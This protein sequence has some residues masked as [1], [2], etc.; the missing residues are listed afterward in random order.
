VAISAEARRLRSEGRDIVALSAGEPD[1]D[2][3]RH[4]RE[5]AKAAIDRGETRYAPPDGLPEL[6]RAV[7]EKFWRENGLEFGSDE[8]MISAGG[9]Q[10]LFNALLATLN[11]GDEV[12]VPAPYWVSY[13]DMV[14]LTGARPVIVPTRSP[15]GFKLE[16]HRLAKALTP[17]TR[18]VIL[19]SP[20]N[21]TGA[22]YSAE[23]LRALAAV[24][25]EHPHVWVMCDDIY[26]QISY[27]PFEFATI[28]AVEPR[29]RER[30]LTV[31]GVSK[32]YAMTGWRIGY[33]GGPAHLVR[34]MTKVQGQST[35][36]ACTVS[37]WAAV[38][39]LDGPQDFIHTSREA[40]RRRP[41]QHKGYHH[42]SQ[43]AQR[44]ADPRHRPPR[45]R[46]HPRAGDP[47][48]RR[49]GRERRRR[50]AAEGH[51][52]RRG[53]RPRPRRDIAERHAA[54]VQDHGLRQVQVR[55]AEKRV[56]GSEEAEDDRRQ[57]SEVPAE[58]RHPRLRRQ[59][60]LRPAFLEEGDK[61]KITLRFRGREMAHTELG[62]ILLERVAATWSSMARSRRSPGSRGARW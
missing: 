6:K 29:L 11:A 60:A 26:E 31:N 36:T 14:A 46:P 10:V 22:G 61:V 40:F 41:K 55:A 54:G 23:D 1:F 12:V 13:P 57:G 45:E 48:D 21:P 24:L 16:P 7:R 17:A 4:V 59:D 18:W 35:T 50:H 56:R 30:T 52:A 19:N 42:S 20:G 5:S 25:F 27:A 43:T 58:H 37:Q 51:D 39:A 47:A 49:R 62:R 38:A 28:A 53:G 9:K 8:V 33:C 44:P 32:A 15:A 34:A 3:P 2:T